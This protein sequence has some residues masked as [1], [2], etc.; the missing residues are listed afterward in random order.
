[1]GGYNVSTKSLRAVQ[2]TGNDLDSVI[3]LARGWSL[4]R[5][6]GFPVTGKRSNVLSSPP[7]ETAHRAWEP[8]HPGLLDDLNGPGYFAVK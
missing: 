4:R 6:C 1:M 8:T 7:E 5:G 2:D 3:K